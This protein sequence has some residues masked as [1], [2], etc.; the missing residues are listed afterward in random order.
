M[1]NFF[2]M[3]DFRIYVSLLIAAVFAVSCSTPQP[4]S[5]SSGESDPEPQTE[6]IYPAW[7]SGTSEFVESD[8]TFTAYGM[9]VDMDSTAAT[10]SAVTKAK[11]NFEQHLSIR[12]ESIRESAAR[13]QDNSEMES[14]EFIF[15]LRNAE[16][17]LSGIVKVSD[18]VANRSRNLNS[19]LGF[20]A[21]TI[22]KEELVRNLESRMDSNRE[23]WRTLRNSAAFE[24]W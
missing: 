15:A 7:F 18:K 2:G 14:P 16:A 19:H 6:S 13:E 22:S 12:L 11:A 24:Q 9:A 21:V 23:A 4:V 1:D 17:S 20:A 10:R 3:P 5:E 8:S